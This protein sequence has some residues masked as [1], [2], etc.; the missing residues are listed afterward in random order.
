MTQN[1]N[2]EDLN[3]E[4]GPTFKDLKEHWMNITSIKNKKNV[5]A[6]KS[7][8]TVNTE[9]YLAPPSIQ[10][11]EDVCLN[12]LLV[13]EEF[14]WNI[15]YHMKNDKNFIMTLLNNNYHKEVWNY[16]PFSMYEDKEI[17]KQCILRGDSFGSSNLHENLLKDKEMIIEAFK[18]K[19]IFDNIKIEYKNDKEINELYLSKYN[20]NYYASE[21]FPK[22]LYNYFSKNKNFIFQ[23]MDNEIPGYYGGPVIYQALPDKLKEDLDIIHYIL[24]KNAS[25]IQHIPESL[26]NDKDFMIYAMQKYKCNLQFSPHLIEDYDLAILNVTNNGANISQTPLYKNDVDL[27]T[28]ALKTYPVLSLFNEENLKNKSLVSYALE[29]DPN[30]CSKLLKKTSYYDD[31]FDIIKQCILFDPNLLKSTSLKNNEELCQIAM[32]YSSDISFLS[33]T[34]YFNK[35]IILDLLD[36]NKANYDT[37]FSIDSMFGNYY[38]N[39]YDIIKK[40][41]EHKG[42]FLKFSPIWSSDINMVKLAMNHKDNKLDNIADIDSSLYTNID[43]MKDFL[44]LNQ[45]NYKKLPL[46]VKQHPD[47]L[48]Y[49]IDNTVKEIHAKNAS[50]YNISFNFYQLIMPSSALENDLHFQK[51]LIKKIPSFYQMIGQNH[52]LKT[53]KELILTFL[54][55]AHPDTI[56]VDDLPNEILKEYENEHEFLSIP[57]LKK[58]ISHEFL[59]SKLEHKSFIDKTRKVKI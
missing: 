30:N 9:F 55:Y 43:L 39:D 11:D 40:M 59:Q 12:A 23:L 56:T 41:V 50:E 22:R 13:G 53:N 27:L 29:L 51:N 35:H 33:K 32:G 8:F 42:K 57:Y 5:F 38:L 16:L 44:A 25:H 10:T 26:R 49:L 1:N 24:T 36:K 54:E 48:N 2:T 6:N 37:F 15:P 31:D 21:A 28:I 14:L 19:N 4:M 7:H 20:A 34:Q 18:V 52:Y 45:Q 3:S 17:F 58:V 47:I 46:P